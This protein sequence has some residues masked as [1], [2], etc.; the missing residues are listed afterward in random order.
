MKVPM[1]HWEQLTRDARRAFQNHSYLHALELNHSA[2]LFSKRHFNGLFE[3]DADRAIAAVLV[4]YFNAIDNH[5]ALYDFNK[6]RSVFDNALRF[7]IVV[8][9]KPQLSEQQFTAILHG[10][11]HLHSEWCRFLQTNEDEISELNITGFQ[12]SI[13]A[14]SDSRQV[15]TPLH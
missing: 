1:K 6:A 4:S 9:S 15:F 14:L 5:L 8:H 10:A 7:L 11:S 13:D 12:A 3:K 2:L